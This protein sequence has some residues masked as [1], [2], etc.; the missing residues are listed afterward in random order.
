MSGNA[1]TNYVPSGDVIASYQEFFNYNVKNVNISSDKY[2]DLIT[3]T[4]EKSKSSGK[5]IIEIESSASK[6]PTKTY[7]TNSNLAYKRAQDAKDNIIKSLVN[8]GIKKENIVIKSV[9]SN[10][11]GPEYN[12]DYNNASVYEKY[13]Y[14]VIKIK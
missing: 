8:K 13:Q 5:V 12:S 1:N 4:V 11:N 2:I 6:V 9:N 10:V 14:V 3:K 7:G